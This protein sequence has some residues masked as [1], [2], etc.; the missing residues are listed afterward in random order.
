M[1]TC[2]VVMGFGV[3][4][5]PQSGRKLNLDMSYENI[6]KPAVEAAGLKCI[7]ADEIQHAGVIDVPMYEQLLEADVVVADVST[8][9][10]NAFYELGVRHALRPHTTIIMAESEL[11]FPFDIGHNAIRRYK[12]LGED[13]GA[14]EARRATQDLAAAIQAIQKAPRDDSPVYT[15]LRGLA[16]PR[17]QAVPA[18]AP[19]FAAAPASPTFTGGGTGD[20]RI[21]TV[22]TL[23]NEAEKARANGQ[24]AAAAFLF[25]Q[26]KEG[27]DK[28]TGNGALDPYIIQQLALA[29]YKSDGSEAG[30]RK[31]CD[32]LET[33]NPL[34]SKDPETLGLW[35]AIHKRLWE[36]TGDRIALDKA[37]Q[38]YETGFSVRNDHYTGINYAFLLN[39]RASATEGDEAL[40]DRV[41]AKRVRQRVIAACE[42]FL[43]EEEL[44]PAERYWAMASEAEAYFGIG[45]LEQARNTM[46]EAVASAPESWMP[47]STQEQIVKLARLLGTADLPWAAKAEGAG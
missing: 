10:P 23:L 30:L 45:E 36:V 26:L 25:G 39:V 1:G 14:T 28:G 20:G 34:T 40:A 38:S 15:Y 22:R 11:A 2:F 19:A 27:M 9:N 6:I 24:W 5:D 46:A 17:M 42:K 33:L 31:A 21:D 32:I 7:R 47:Q 35:G 8:M 18:P 29:T 16:P 4:T 37:I 13:I 43:Q 44:K 41:L 12:H 3:K